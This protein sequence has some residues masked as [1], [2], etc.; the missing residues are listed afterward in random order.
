MSPQYLTI[1]PLAPLHL[2]TVKPGFSFLA[3]REVLPGSV[4]RG[5]L[6]QYL[7]HTGQTSAIKGYVENLRIGWFFPSRAASLWPYVLPAT[8]LQCKAAD[9]FASRRSTGHGVLDS[10]IPTLAYTELERLG[11]TF[12]V[13]FRLV[14][15]SCQKRMERLSG[16]YVKHAHF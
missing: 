9:G 15:A 16:L 7:I 11:A 4:V 12:P 13:P 6:A 1:T 10:L 3:T 2:G 8:A 5:A 14:C